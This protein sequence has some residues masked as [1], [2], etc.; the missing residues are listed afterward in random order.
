MVGFASVSL[1]RAKLLALTVVFAFV[2]GACGGGG[3]E[4][5]SG[6]SSG[7]GNELKNLDVG[8]TLELPP[9]GFVGPDGKPTGFEYEM[10]L[11]AADKLGY[12]VNVVQTPFEQAFVA[13]DAGKYRMFVGGIFIR[14]ER[15]NGTEATLA[16]SVPIYEEDQVIT[17]TTENASSIQS[18]ADLNGKN[19]AIEA[20]GSTADAVSGA[21]LSENPDVNIHIDYYNNT[22]DTVLALQQGRDDAMLQSRIVTLDAIKKEPDLQISGAVPD[23]GFPVGFVFQPGDSLKGEFDQALNELKQDG[24][25]AAIWKKWFG[26]EPPP[27]SSTVTVVPEVTESTCK[28]GA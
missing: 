23:T 1:S 11:A 10:L 12:S 4:T 15:L 2:A 8:M 26:S 25:L 20:K 13:L 3:N 5:S 22:T 24:T 18:L 17:T 6:T 16:F 14:C 28:N 27:G 7:G 19:L 21:F 9:Q